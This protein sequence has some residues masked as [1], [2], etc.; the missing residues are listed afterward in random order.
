MILVES[1]N[2]TLLQR[3]N[4]PV[5]TA[6]NENNVDVGQRPIQFCWESPAPVNPEALNFKH[7]ALDPRPRNPNSCYKASL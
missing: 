5:E 3:M 2:P 4:S 6:T 7:L 1:G